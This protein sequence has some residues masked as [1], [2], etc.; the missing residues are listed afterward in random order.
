MSETKKS[1]TTKTHAVND[2]EST[3]K[4]Q[5]AS[6]RDAQ[7]KFTK[8]NRGGPGN[9]FARQT[10]AY[11]KAMRQRVT[12]VDIQEITAML[13]FKAKTG[14]LAAAKMVLTFCVGKPAETVDPD[15]LDVEE[16]KLM[17][18][19]T[20]DGEP[21]AQLLNSPSLSGMLPFLQVLVPIVTEAM[22]K[23]MME[24]ILDPEK[25]RAELRQQAEERRQ[26]E[27]DAE[28]YGD[29]VDDLALDEDDASEGSGAFMD[30]VGQ[31]A[32]MASR[33]PMA[34]GVNGGNGHPEKGA[35]SRNGNNG[36]HRPSG[37]GRNGKGRRG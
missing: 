20:V 23:K 14:D 5:A 9:P 16:W 34:N 21:W 29:E 7:G 35:P 11:R 17:Q 1:V 37:N 30:L 36:K 22:M 10:A 31:L 3:A 24:A 6:G 28:L 4:P 8:G 33:M 15:R 18:E 2:V 19:S 25:A 13:L 12:E 26:K 32:G 27:E